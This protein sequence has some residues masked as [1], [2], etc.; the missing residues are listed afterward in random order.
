M[1]AEESPCDSETVGKVELM[2]KGN[3]FHAL[4]AES[5][6]IWSLDSNPG[7]GA[8]PKNGKISKKPEGKRLER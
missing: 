5:T 6:Q 4:E 2:L 8:R 3:L 7:P 1:V